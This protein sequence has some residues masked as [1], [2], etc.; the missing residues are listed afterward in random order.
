MSFCSLSLWCRAASSTAFDAVR[1]VFW[2]AVAHSAGSLAASSRAAAGS[3]Q[4][5]L[6]RSTSR[7]AAQ[8]NKPAPCQ[9]ISSRAAAPLVR[10]RWAER[11]TLKLL[12]RMRRSAKSSRTCCGMP[13]D[14]ANPIPACGHSGIT[15]QRSSTSQQSFRSLSSRRLSKGSRTN[16]R[17]ARPPTL[18]SAPSALSATAGSWDPRTAVRI[19]VSAITAAGTDAT[20][21]AHAIFSPRAYFDHPGPGSTFPREGDVDPDTAEE[22]LR[23]GPRANWR[24]S[25]HGSVNVAIRVLMLLHLQM[26]ARLQILRFRASTR[27]TYAGAEQHRS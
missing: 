8:R 10:G 12:T 26:Q 23:V 7:A 13:L 17:D 27:P 21:G 19:A 15:H 9:C 3:F 2:L 14:P 6:I 11:L 5:A 24:L 18:A 16:S 25:D 22:G 4:A 1:M 20:D